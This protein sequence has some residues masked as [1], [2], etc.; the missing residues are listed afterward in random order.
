MSPRPG[1]HH[2]K[3]RISHEVCQQSRLAY[4]AGE[5]LADIAARL[6]LS[7]TAIKNRIRI[8]G[9]VIR[10]IKVAVKLAADNGKM[11]GSR[12]SG[13]DHYNWNGGRRISDKGYV[14]VM[15]KWHG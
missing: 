2:K 3:R 14:C 12:R 7:T 13:A 10:S 6:G 4:E 15:A 1:Y 5:S 11:H 8:A 9:G